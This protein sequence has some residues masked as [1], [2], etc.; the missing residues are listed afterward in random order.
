LKQKDEALALPQQ[1][2]PIRDEKE[3]TI[4]IHAEQS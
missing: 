3:R 1:A 2:T 4:N